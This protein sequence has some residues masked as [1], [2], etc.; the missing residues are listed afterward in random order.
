MGEAVTRRNARRVGFALLVAATVIAAGLLAAVLLTLPAKPAF[1]PDVLQ[2]VDLC[3][4]DHVRVTVSVAEAN[5]D[6]ILRCLYQNGV[7]IRYQGEAV[8]MRAV[9]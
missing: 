8:E 5:A 2:V 6:A 3:V 4:E 9:G 7:T 1:P